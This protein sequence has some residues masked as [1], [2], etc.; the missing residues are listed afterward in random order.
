MSPLGFKGW[1]KSALF[2][3]LSIEVQSKPQQSIQSMHQM[4][5]VIKAV[6]QSK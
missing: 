1:S 3:Q 2:I 5:G 6:I 4:V